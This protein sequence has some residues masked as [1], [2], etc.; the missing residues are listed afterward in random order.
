MAPPSARARDDDAAFVGLGAGLRRR[1]DADDNLDIGRRRRRRREPLDAR[2]A[3]RVHSAPGVSS[4]ISAN[5]SWRPIVR[6]A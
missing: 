6:P 3:A 1:I 2:S 4:T 5:S